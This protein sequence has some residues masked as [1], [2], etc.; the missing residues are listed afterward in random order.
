MRGGQEIGCIEVTNLSAFPV[1]VREVG[2][3]ING[4]L[5]KKTRA[6]ISLPIVRDGGSWPRRL[7]SRASVSLYFDWGGLKH[8]NKR[9]YILTDCGTVGYGNSP[10]LKS[11][12][13]RLPS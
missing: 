1:T 12:R 4:G 9:A 2:F 10:A 3:T 13:K 8:N 7:E 6:V 5:R 11:M